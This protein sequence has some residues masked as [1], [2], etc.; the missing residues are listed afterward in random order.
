M[1]RR[2]AA[3]YGLWRSAADRSRRH[4]EKINGRDVM[5]RYII[6]LIIAG[7]VGAILAARKGRNP[8]VWFFLCAIAPIIIAI[9]LVLPAMPVRGYTKKCPY[10]A[11][12]IKDE[13]RLCKHC[14]KA[15]PIEMVRERMDNQK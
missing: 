6:L 4:E 10:C 3:G 8:L 12:I 14:G 7:F 15:Q 11:E 5:F 13:A 1:E 9:I 2:F